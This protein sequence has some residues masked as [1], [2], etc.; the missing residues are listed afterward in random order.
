MIKL[1]IKILREESRYIIEYI[2]QNFLDV[3]K[4][5]IVAKD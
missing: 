2:L 5:Y 1:L 3:S 4:K